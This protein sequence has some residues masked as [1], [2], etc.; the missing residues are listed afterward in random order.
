MKISLVSRIVSW[1]GGG[2]M[3]LL[4]LQGTGLLPVLTNWT[5]RSGKPKDGALCRR[6]F[7]PR[8]LF[9]A[10]PVALLKPSLN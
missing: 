1:I 9:L 7:P 3:I 8:F 6:F 2:L 4:V 5:Q 10:E